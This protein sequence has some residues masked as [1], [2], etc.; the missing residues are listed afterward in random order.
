MVRLAAQQHSHL[1]I[2]SLSYRPA[3]VSQHRIRSHIACR[4]PCE[5]FP[6]IRAVV[7][8]APQ[9]V[10]SS[11][12]IKRASSGS[13][14]I[15]AIRALLYPLRRKN[16]R[17]ADPRNF[18]LRAGGRPRRHPRPPSYH[19]HAG[20]VEG[21]ASKKRYYLLHLPCPPLPSLISLFE[22]LSDKPA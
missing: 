4:I 11:G 15:S 7:L 10:T 5:G 9:R 20:L 22:T 16:S 19:M 18:S 13:P 21:R 3:T 14:I 6:T 8:N 1:S 17:R 12:A 2:R